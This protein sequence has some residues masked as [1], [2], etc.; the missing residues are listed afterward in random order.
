MLTRHLVFSAALAVMA[1]P[2]P[3]GAQPASS[4]SVRMNQ[5]STEGVE[6][7]QR[8]GIWDVTETV[9]ASPGSA[10]VVTTGLVADRRMIGSALQ[11]VLRPPSDTSDAA[12]NRVDYLSY[13]RVE[14]RWDYVSMDT[15]APVGI[16]PAT[17]FTRGDG[18]AIVLSFQPFAIAGDGQAVTGQMLRMDMRVTRQ[19]PDRDLK[20]QRFI[21]ADGTGTAWLAH[22]YSYVRRR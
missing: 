22:A 21:L 1:L 5:P 9:W 2:S 15:R 12:I 8:A 13:D 7:A 4:A 14:G 6:L 17:S 10:P 11:E 19:G 3:S 16:M 18:D 20:E